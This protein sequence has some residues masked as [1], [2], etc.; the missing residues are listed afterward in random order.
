MHFHMPRQGNRQ[1]KR[2]AKMDNEIRCENKPLLSSRCVL[3]LHPA[4]LYDS[5]KSWNH[6]PDHH[7][8]TALYHRQGLELG[9][10]SFSKKFPC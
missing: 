7:L 10:A 1:Q 5:L 2:I 8:L 4:P 6:G 9:Q 3:G